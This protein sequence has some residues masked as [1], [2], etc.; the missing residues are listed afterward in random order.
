MKYLFISLLSILL[1]GCVTTV[2]P[3]KS[4]YRINTDIQVQEHR[5][6]G[7]KEKSLKVGQAFSSSTLMSKHMM[8]AIGD[9]KQ[10]AYAESLWAE[11]PNLVVTSKIVKLMRD[12]NLFQSVQ[13][14][15]S[16]ARND[17]ILE[18]DI[19]DFLQYFDESSLHSYAHISLT[20]TLIDIK[21][22][23]V[24]A[25]ENFDAKVDVQELNA[26]GGVKGLKEALNKILKD[27]NAWIIGVCE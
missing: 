21:S 12:T 5:S 2:T 11:N 6:K 13:I 8:Y 9:T 22:N 16:R 1:G 3:A 25:T 14:S 10:Y 18:I 23:R 27:T 24:I 15:K 20:L 26:Q 17:L 4:E 19:E 7:C